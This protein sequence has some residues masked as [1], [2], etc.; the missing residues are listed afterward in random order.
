MSRL[1]RSLDR[2]LVI[3]LSAALI[4]AVPAN[5]Q[6]SEPR[7]R[8]TAAAQV[9]S[10]PAPV[11][12]HNSP[13]VAVNPTNRELVVVES[14]PRGTRACNVHISMDD[15]RT[16]SRG[17]ELMV[18]P[19]TD[20]SFYAEYGPYASMVFGSDGTLYV[21]FVASAFL[22]RERDATPRHVF[23][24]RSSDGGRTFSKTKVYDAPDGNPDRGLN[25]GPTLAVDP[26]HP[27]RV[28][29]G[30][31][32]GIRGT[33][34]KENLKS[35]IAASSDGGSTFRAPV[36]LADD[37]GGDYP[38]AAVGPDGTV[39]AVI[40]TRTGTFPPLPAGQPSPVRPIIYRRSTDAG[41][42]WSPPTEIDPGNQRSG[43]PRPPV[44]ASDQSGTL[45]MAWYSNADPNNMSPG[46]KGDLEIFLRRSTDGGKTWSER[47]VLND[48]GDRGGV[49]ANQF[50]PGISIAASGRVNVAWYDGR[51]SPK[52]P[53]ESTGNDDNG[54]QDVFYTSSTDRGRTWRQNLRITDRIIDRSVG[55]WN[56]NVASHH[57]VGIASTDDSVYFAWQD[58][59]NGNALTQAED[60]YFASLK[61]APSGVAAET[62]P[63][64][65]LWAIAGAGVAL[66]M[67][68]AMI[69]ALAI[70][71]R[72]RP[73]QRAAVERASR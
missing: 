53:P 43:S 21:A 54:F 59:R 11:R 16:W 63:G 20:C 52:L 40:W 2:R 55:V 12:N 28:Y 19:F 39:H 34:A 70:A 56:N 50:D 32:Q 25:K 35:N 29:V 9:T 61:L 22:N 73:F 71:R 6:D 26:Q 37:R 15:G 36:N 47:R 10:N 7:E 18:K 72:A 45:Y 13:Q 62:Q 41:K 69:T 30:W 4:L 3:I 38:W 17:G 64:A 68:I 48:D 27:R 58:S 5:A 14:D 46:F 8:V 57:N 33:P 67:G 44:L 31:R 60:I 24:A 49:R 51:L 42:T 23:L 66:G 65:P 1:G